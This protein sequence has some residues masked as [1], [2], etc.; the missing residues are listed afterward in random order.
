M[1]CIGGFNQFIVHRKALGVFITE[2]ST[3]SNAQLLSAP[4]THKSIDK[5][6]KGKRRGII[7]K[8][9]WLIPMVVKITTDMNSII[10][11]FSKN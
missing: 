3:G 10:H 9:I 1:I 2:V 6:N 8:K 11:T 4:D 5:H 7:W